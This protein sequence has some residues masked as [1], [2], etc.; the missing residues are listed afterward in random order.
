MA[1][2]LYPAFV[3]INY[4]STYG[5]HKMIIPTRAWQAT[6]ITGTI[7]SYTA[8]DSSQVDAELM[9]NDLVTTFLPFFLATTSFDAATVYTLASPTSPQLPQAT[10]ALTAVGTSTSTT[11][12]KAG[13][14]HYSFRDTGFNLS[15]ITFLDAPVNVGFEP[16]TPASFSVEDDSLKLEFTAVNRAWSSRAGFRPSVLRRATYDLNGKLRKEYG[17]A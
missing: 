2:S 3:L 4:H 12:A 8:W 5:P 10:V 17:M 16:K 6:N 1:N 13:E 11:Q 9:V 7:G 15:G 14:T